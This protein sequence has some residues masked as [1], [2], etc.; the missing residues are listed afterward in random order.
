M[1]KPPRG[2]WLPEP[3][4]LPLEDLNGEVRRVL[5]TSRAAAG[6]ADGGAAVGEDPYA[7]LGPDA[8][9][10]IAERDLAAAME[11][12]LILYDRLRRQRYAAAKKQHA[13]QPGSRG[14]ASRP[15]SA[16]TRLHPYD[17]PVLVDVAS[18]AA[19]GR[20]TD[21]SSIFGER[22]QGRN[23]INGI[24]RDG[25]DQSWAAVEGVGAS[26]TIRFPNEFLLETIGWQQRQP[27][28]SHV[29]EVRLRFSNGTEQFLPLRSSVSEL[30][31]PPAP[32][33]P[34][35]TERL[36][37]Y[38]IEPV[39]CSWVRFEVT[40]MA[41]GPDGANA[42]ACLISCYAAMLPSVAKLLREAARGKPA[43]ARSVIRGGS[44]GAPPVSTMAATSSPIRP[45]TSSGRGSRPMSRGISQRPKT[46]GHQSARYVFFY[47]IYIAF[48]FILFC[49]QLS[50]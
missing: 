10:A 40:G 41:M 23:A 50:S 43:S 46:A 38:T 29:S 42:G 36:I 22:F 5:A 20:V 33:A 18:Q 11:T 4:V 25:P 9:R 26:I 39:R 32:G 27:R 37:E 30:A 8:A 16:G 48:F 31:E 45:S 47:I 1:R 34:M 44:A 2:G 28:I 24:G 6:A 15:D 3:D 13:P 49:K 21:C 14:P 35:P 7:S 17:T 19:G 12:A